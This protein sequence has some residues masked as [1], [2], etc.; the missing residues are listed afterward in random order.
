VF[1]LLALP[2]HWQAPQR[3][4][5]MKTS[6]IAA[7]VALASF[8]AY[9]QDTP[10]D[11]PD[12]AVVPVPVPVPAPVPA[13]EPSEVVPAPVGP[14][15]EGP[16]Y[17]APPKLYSVIGMGVLIGGNFNTFFGT[18]AQEDTKVGAGW[19]A[20][21]ELGT[22]SHLG[23]EFSYVG[24]TN[25]ITALGVDSRAQLLSNGMSGLVRLNVLT[26]PVQPYAGV[27]IGYKRYQVV[28]TTTNSSDITDRSDVPVV[29]AAFGLAVRGMG[30][31]LDT[32]FAV[33]APISASIIPGSAMTSWN[34]GASIGA[35]F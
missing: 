26:G 3:N 12:P 30:L 9:A 34:L 2:L 35:E 17:L 7:V 6:L 25:E 5:T 32:R 14:S 20:R 31:I 16:A 4:N 23:G 19:D 10:V 8:G 28:N 22:R 33:D 21:V 13:P 11:A 29:P 27:G 15:Y 18:A 24:S 1:P